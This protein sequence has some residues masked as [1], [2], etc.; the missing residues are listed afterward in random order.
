M[1]LS[2]QYKKAECFE[3]VNSSVGPEEHTKIYAD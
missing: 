1:P 3:N 2:P